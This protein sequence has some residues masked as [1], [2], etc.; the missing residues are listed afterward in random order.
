MYEGWADTFYGLKKNA[1]AGANYMPLFAVFIAWFLWFFCVMP[2][3]YAL[4]G[5][6]LCAVHPSAWTAVLAATGVIGFLAELGAAWRVTRFMGVAGRSA[7]TIP[8]GFIF[9]FLVF[10]GSVID[11]HRGGNFWAGRRVG[12]VQSLAEAGKI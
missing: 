9:Y 10:V 3:A 2:V 5:V 4:I 1:Y 6:W 7:W 12:K 8:A 11:H